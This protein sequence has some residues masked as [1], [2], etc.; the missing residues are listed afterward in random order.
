MVYDSWQ[1]WAVS[2][3]CQLA[4][5]HYLFMF[6]CKNGDLSTNYWVITQLIGWITLPRNQI[7]VLS[8]GKAWNVYP[9]ALDIAD[10][11]FFGKSLFQEIDKESKWKRLERM[12]LD[13][14]RFLKWRSIEQR[15]WSTNTENY[16]ENRNLFDWLEKQC[17]GDIELNRIVSM[18]RLVAKKRFV[19]V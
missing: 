13:F 2:I 10:F 16:G 18:Y 9:S 4:T 12:V 5:H 15:I 1:N 17:L 7:W 11:H 14:N 3:S 8:P 6:L 19:P